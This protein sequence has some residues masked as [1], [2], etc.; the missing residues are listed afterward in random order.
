MSKKTEVLAFSLAHEQ[1]PLRACRLADRLGHTM[2]D[3]T[4]RVSYP[5][6]WVKTTA[7]GPV[8]IASYAISHCDDPGTLLE[9]LRRDKRKGVRVALAKNPH[10]NDEIRAILSEIAS[11]GCPGDYEIRNALAGPGL[12]PDEARRSLLANPVKFIGDYPGVGIVNL[13]LSP[14]TSTA[15]A[16][17]TLRRLIS[18]KKSPRRGA[19]AKELVRGLLGVGE[20]PN[21][22]EL[23][24]KVGFGISEILTMVPEHAKEILASVFRN[25]YDARGPELSRE[26]VDLMIH[27]DTAP[28]ISRSLYRSSRAT[29]MFSRADVARLVK[30][31]EWR[32][33]L[34][35]TGLYADE[36]VNLIVYSWGHCEPS[37]LETLLERSYLVKALC[38]G[39][40]EADTTRLLKMLNDSDKELLLVYLGHVREIA[41]A[42]LKS[43][44]PGVL[45]NLARRRNGLGYRYHLRDSYAPILKAITSSDDPLLG[46]LLEHTSVEELIQY[47]SGNW[48]IQGDVCLCPKA[49]E[50][51]GLLKRL[52]NTSSEG[53][54]NGPQDVIYSLNTEVLTPEVLFVLVDQVADPLGHFLVNPVTA[55]Y[56]SGQ[57]DT[58]GLD[59]DIIIE[60][61]SEHPY[62]A[63]KDTMRFLGA[64]AKA[65]RTLSKKA[66]Q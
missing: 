1:D 42:I 40:N 27:Y 30:V 51:E 20:S 54:K 65:T 35:S 23:S 18:Q 8:E 41:L 63:F 62:M 19:V 24:R 5:P 59:P 9:I 3:V 50:I 26:V 31:P 52:T 58:L 32:D 7:K 17:R 10:I 36:I 57:L 33:V 56:I 44:S 64:V 13:L 55:E 14:D 4:P 53:I 47:L 39:L 38:E 34:M 43:L 49:G 22:N 21:W 12:S 11:Q 28:L 29:R 48:K 45:L 60:H 2:I 61:L 6:H 25:V 46:A 66:S 15:G 16:K 37:F